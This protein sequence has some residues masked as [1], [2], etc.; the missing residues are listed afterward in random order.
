MERERHD[1]EEAVVEA[2]KSGL[3]RKGSRPHSRSSCNVATSA[4]TSSYR[5][6][7]LAT[8]SKPSRPVTSLNSAHISPIFTPKEPT[9]PTTPSPTELRSGPSRTEST[10]RSLDNFTACSEKAPCPLSVPSPHSRIPHDTCALFVPSK[11]SGTAIP[12]NITHIP[13]ETPS[14]EHISSSIKYPA[15]SALSASHNTGSTEENVFKPLNSTSCSSKS[16]ISYASSN[17]SLGPSREA[18]DTH[19]PAT[20]ASEHPTRATSQ[21]SPPRKTPMNKLPPQ[22]L[23]SPIRPPTGSSAL[24]HSL[25]GPMSSRL[26]PPPACHAVEEATATTG[27]SNGLLRSFT[28]I[29]RKQHVQTDVVTWPK[30]NASSAFAS[31]V[32]PVSGAVDEL[33]GTF[34]AVERCGPTWMAGAHTSN[35]YGVTPDFH[36]KDE[37]DLA[38]LHF[39]VDSSSSFRPMQPRLPY[40]FSATSATKYS[41]KSD[42]HLQPEYIPARD[43][44]SP[45]LEIDEVYPPDQP[46]RSPPRLES[47]SREPQAPVSNRNAR[48]GRAIPRPQAPIS[49]KNAKVSYTVPVR[50]PIDMSVAGARSD[51]VKRKRDAY[52]FVDDSDEEWSTLP[53]KKGRKSTS[54]AALGAGVKTTKPFRIPGLLGDG[55]RTGMSATSDRRVITFLPPPLARADAAM[56]KERPLMPPRSS[57]SRTVSNVLP[58][59][60]A[61]IPLVTPQRHSPRALSSK[62]RT[63]TPPSSKSELQLSAEDAGSPARNAS[64]SLADHTDAAVTNVDPVI[65]ATD[66]TAQDITDAID[67]LPISQISEQRISAPPCSS[68]VPTTDDCYS[69]KEDLQQ[70]IYFGAIKIATL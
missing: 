49:S 41:P 40:P 10:F 28:P 27:S 13:N 31:S 2:L 62:L 14:N 60:H 51:A 39:P 33:G 54:K 19:A 66:N 35:G 7:A 46:L 25:K 21:G 34:D 37:D 18:F 43:C 67:R 6:H 58:K 8:P 24:L 20:H 16:A 29:E 12:P 5:A 15:I 38:E 70:T 11:L 48:V 3:Q 57:P 23:S 36:V 64:S 45:K 47:F 68:A 9:T 44:A 17:T 63:V 22:S 61:K 4:T 1:E 53:P 56:S 52:S 42:P 32:A 69:D 59:V 55:Q 65:T 30:Q 26:G 50:P